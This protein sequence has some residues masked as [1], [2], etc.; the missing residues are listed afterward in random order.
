MTIITCVYINTKQFKKT[1]NFY[2]L[3]LEKEIERIFE[4]RWAQI[5]ITDDIRLGFLNVEYDR[6]MIE[7][8]KNLEQHY[9]EEFI[10]N[11]PK[12]YTTGNSIILNLKTDNILDEYNRVKKIAPNYISELQYVNF[13]FPYNFFIIKDPEG[14]IIEIADA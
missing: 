8:G 6:R 4:D 12:N 7:K 1:V 13:I 9:N 5:K 11:M 2:T 3:L 14:N 10:K